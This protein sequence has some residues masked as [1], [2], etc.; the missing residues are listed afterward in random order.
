MSLQE[1]CYRELPYL[2]LVF[3]YGG[4]AAECREAEGGVER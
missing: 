2:M 4:G 1:W 3:T